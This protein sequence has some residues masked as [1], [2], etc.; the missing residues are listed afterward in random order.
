MRKI[1]AWF[2]A[3]LLT[4]TLILFGICFAGRQLIIPAMG[5]EGAAVN[6]SVIREEKE[7][8]RERITA[9]AELYGFS[10][11]P[12]IETVNEE[13]LRVSALEI[14]GGPLDDLI[15]GRWYA[16]AYHVQPMGDVGHVTVPTVREEV[17]E[18]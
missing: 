17:N 11:E 14:S 5:E 16:T 6:E 8:A 9:L 3:F 7:L 13:T 10:A 4:G 1:I 15:D 18:V 12:V 2:L